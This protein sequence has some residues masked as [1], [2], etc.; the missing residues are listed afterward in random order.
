MC[1]FSFFLK[2]ICLLLDSTFN[3]L[4][5]TLPYTTASNNYFNTAQIITCRTKVEEALEDFFEIYT[6]VRENPRSATIS[7]TDAISLNTFLLLILRLVHATITA[8]ET[9]GTPGAHLEDTSMLAEDVTKPKKPFDWK[10]PFSDLSAYIGIRPS[11][12]KLVR[13]VKTSL[14]VLVSAIVVFSLR[15]RLQA[16]GWVYW[17]PMTTALVSE[18]SEGSTIR[19]SFQRLMAVLLGSTYA[20]V[21]VLVTQDHLPVGIC[22]CLFVGLMGYLKTDPRK[23]YFAS[24]C[25]QSASIITFLSNQGGKMSASNNAVLARTSLTFLGIF[26][27]VLISNLIFPVTARALIKKKVKNNS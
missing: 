25:A 9:S 2:A 6:Q 3:F 15:E 7:N 10:K 12:G 22:I 24:V 17:A 21:I 18:S 23:E 20:Y 16:Y 4:D 13:S 19:I 26:I 27:H 11:S 5:S 1:F 8:A 14:S